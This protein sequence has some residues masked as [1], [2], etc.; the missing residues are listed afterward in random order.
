MFQKLFSA[1]SAICLGF[2]SLVIAA[3][4]ELSFSTSP[5]A[6]LEAGDIVM[7]ATPSEQDLELQPGETSDGYITV[8]NI[9]RLAFELRAS[10]SP[11]RVANDD[12]TPDYSTDTSYTRLSNWIKLEQDSY[13]LEPGQKTRINFTVTVPEGVAGGGQYAAIMLQSDSGIKEEGSAVNVNARIAAVLY[14]HV[15]GGE[16][17]AE[18]EL[19]DHSLPGFMFNDKFAVSQTVRNSGNTDFKVAQKL[20]VTNFFTN[21]DVINPDSVSEDGQALGYSNYTVLPGT[22]RT[23][24]LNWQDAP[25]LGLFRVTQEISFL[26]QEYTFSQLVLICPTWLLVL[27]IALIIAIII[28]LIIKIRRKARATE[29][30]DLF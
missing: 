18:G 2:G 20:T 29:P 7:S 13:H 15:N 3:M 14:G 23:G 27:V 5:V 22:S 6:A 4:A 17:R 1:I 12:Y 19:V 10:V 28:S 30:S 24:I 8:T 21:R 9:G 26:D 25:K 16:M 11:F